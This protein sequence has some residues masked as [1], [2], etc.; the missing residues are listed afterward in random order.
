MINNKFDNWQERNKKLLEKMDEWRKN[1]Y[2]R[3]NCDEWKKWKYCSHLLKARVKYFK[4][5]IDDQINSLMEC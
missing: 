1:Y 2:C 3:N 5:E 4:N